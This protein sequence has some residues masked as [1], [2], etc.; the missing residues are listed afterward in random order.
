[1]A[2]DRAPLSAG[3]TTGF[4]GSVLDAEGIALI[5]GL[6]DVLGAGVNVL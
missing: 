3:G 2:A 6:Q 4:L 5:A 1:M